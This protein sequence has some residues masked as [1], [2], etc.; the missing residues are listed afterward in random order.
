[1]A[2][3]LT[4][5]QTQLVLRALRLAEDHFVTEAREAWEASDP[6]KFRELTHDAA[7]AAWIRSTIESEKVVIRW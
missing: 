7:E 4:D 3:H 6:P 5:A 2:T 1:M